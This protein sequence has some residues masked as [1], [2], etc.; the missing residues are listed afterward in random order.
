[1]NTYVEY[2]LLWFAVWLACIAIGGGIG[3]IAGRRMWKDVRKY[4]GGPMD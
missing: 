1:M 2:D 3:T 4:Q